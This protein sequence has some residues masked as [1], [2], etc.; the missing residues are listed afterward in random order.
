M[1]GRHSFLFPIFRWVFSFRTSRSLVAPENPPSPPPSLVR[2]P[3]AFLWVKKFLRKNAKFPF[4]SQVPSPV[5]GPQRRAFHVSRRLALPQARLPDVQNAYSSTI[6][7]FC[8]FL[9]LKKNLALLPNQQR[10]LLRQLAICWAAKEP[11]ALVDYSYCHYDHADSSWRRRIF[12]Q[13]MARTQRL[14][15]VKSPF[16]RKKFMAIFFRYGE[17]HE[18][19]HKIEELQHNLGRMAH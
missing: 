19:L 2:L 1:N 5:G 14:L 3:M 6:R 10:Y 16:W 9:D 12:E 13:V 11:V 7:K 8:F 18:L 4:F 15:L 17:K